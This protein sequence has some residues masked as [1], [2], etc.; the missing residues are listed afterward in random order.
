MLRF[1]FFA[2]PFQR[3]LPCSLWSFRYTPFLP[4]TPQNIVYPKQEPPRLNHSISQAT[5]H[6]FGVSALALPAKKLHC[7][8]KNRASPAAKP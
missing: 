2:H 6:S 3:S 5:F 8:A 1:V 4:L 7:T